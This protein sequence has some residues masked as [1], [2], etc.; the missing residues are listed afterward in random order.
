MQA[1]QPFLEEKFNIALLSKQVNSPEYKISKAIK[2]KFGIHFPEY[3]NR[4][5]I[6]YIEYNFSKNPE[7]KKYT[8]D[9][10]ALSAGFNS[11][12]AFYAAFKKIKGITPT[13]FFNRS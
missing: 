2:F 1:H 9:G 4:Y 5:R 12:N 6:D 8:I 11:R 7:W 13:V 10:M 3:V